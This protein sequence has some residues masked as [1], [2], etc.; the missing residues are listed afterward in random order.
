M[1]KIIDYNYHTDL[2]VDIKCTTCLV[3]GG[4]IKVSQ[5]IIIF[6]RNLQNYKIRS[7]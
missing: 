5:E 3:D 4:V 7:L 1:V 6:Y 2:L